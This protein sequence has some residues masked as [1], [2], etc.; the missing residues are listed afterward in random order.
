MGIIL[1][2]QDRDRYFGELHATSVSGSGEAKGALQGRSLQEPQEITPTAT[3]TA[4]ATHSVSL[5][6][7]RQVFTYTFPVLS[8]NHYKFTGQS[9]YSRH[10]DRAS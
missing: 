2:M 3:T 5:E 4:S 1:Y 6:K 7:A 9:G 10:F 8:L